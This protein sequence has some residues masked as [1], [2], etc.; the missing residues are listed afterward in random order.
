MGPED[1]SKRKKEPKISLSSHARNKNLRPLFNANI[2]PIKEQ[3]DLR[4]SLLTLGMVFSQSILL[5]LFSQTFSETNPKTFN[6]I[7]KSEEK[8]L[9]SKICLLPIF[10]LT[11][12]SIDSMHSKVK[13]GPPYRECQKK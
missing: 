6:L 9:F 3:Y 11:F 5:S 7:R 1:Q 4:K 8:G 2:P 12:F 10:R 13:K